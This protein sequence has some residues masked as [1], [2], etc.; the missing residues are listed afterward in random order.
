MLVALLYFLQ[1]RLVYIPWSAINATPADVGLQYE[2][3]FLD[4][5]DGVKIHGWMVPAADEA[6]P[7][8][9]FF[10]GNAGNISHRLETLQLIHELGLSVLIIDYRG[11]GRSEGRPS[12][13]GTYRDAQ[14]AWDYLQQQSIPPSSIILWGRSLGGAIAADLATRTSPGALILESTFT[15]IPDLGATLYPYL[16]VRLLSRFHYDTK[17]KI[18]HISSA[19]LVIHSPDDEVV[20]YAHGRKIY[21]ALPADQRAFLEIRGSHNRG[22]MESQV[23]YRSGV[24]QFILQNAKEFRSGDDGN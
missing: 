5:A 23:E 15:S 1:H 9:L 18:P 6:A 2:D 16:P 24:A 14:A 4:A 17:A 20:P 3:V 10:H 7:T 13:S 22:F 21:D 19:V 11:Y 12:E 8:V